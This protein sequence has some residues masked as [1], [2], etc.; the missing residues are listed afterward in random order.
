MNHL[1]HNL[2]YVF[3]EICCIVFSGAYLQES[4]HRIPALGYKPT[5]TYLELNLMEYHR[6]IS[7]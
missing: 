2:M 7:E 4:V 1:Q 6:L 5:Y 3:S